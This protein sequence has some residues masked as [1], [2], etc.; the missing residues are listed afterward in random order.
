MPGAESAE[1]EATLGFRRDGDGKGTRRS[2]EGVLAIG[3]GPVA[4]RVSDEKLGVVSNGRDLEGCRA[5][6]DDELVVA[7]DSG[8]TESNDHSRRQVVTDKGIDGVDDSF[9]WTGIEAGAQCGKGG[10]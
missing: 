5:P 7:G 4:A 8:V 3:R 2:G 1:K 6:I 10:I 9:K